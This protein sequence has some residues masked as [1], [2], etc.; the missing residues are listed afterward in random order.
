MFNYIIKNGRRDL[1]G[2]YVALL[3]VNSV[4]NIHWNQGMDW[5]HLFLWPS[6]ETELDDETI[7]LR[8]PYSE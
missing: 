4:Y 6:Y 1:D 5:D 2:G 8:F 3:P 7:V